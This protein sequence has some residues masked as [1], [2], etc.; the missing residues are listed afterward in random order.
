LWDS[1][2]AYKPT[3]FFAPISKIDK[4]GGLALE[5][6][7][8]SDFRNLIGP[9]NIVVRT[10]AQAGVK[11]PNLPRTTCLNPKAAAK[12]CVETAGQLREQ[13]GAA[14]YAFVAHPFM[15]ARASAWV[16]AEPDNP[17]I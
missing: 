14:D 6:K 7:L 1:A 3:L 5:R 10:S 13:G 15:P 9:D 4:A 12:W 8:A 16:R 11:P 17:I 2:S